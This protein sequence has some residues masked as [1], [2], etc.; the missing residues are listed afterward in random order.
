MVAGGLSVG[1][2]VMQTAHK[3]GE[4]EASLTADLLKNLHSAGTVSYAFV[5]HI[6]LTLTK[7][8]CTIFPCF[9]FYY[10]SERGLFPD[11]EFV[12]DLELPPDFIPHNQDNEVE[13]FELLT[14]HVCI[15]FEYALII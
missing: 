3:E 5:C 13:K 7:L 10:E 4:E 6:M 11:T 14:A 1:N 8:K 15:Y 2:S 12:F 9:S